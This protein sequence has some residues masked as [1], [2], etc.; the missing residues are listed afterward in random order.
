MYKCIYTGTCC[1]LVNVQ[2]IYIYS[3]EFCTCTC[4]NSLFLVPCPAVCS[5]VR[6]ISSP[7]FFCHACRYTIDTFVFGTVH[8]CSITSYSSSSN[9]AWSVVF[10]CVTTLGFRRI[11]VHV[12][13]HTFFH[14]PCRYMYMYTVDIGTLPYHG[15]L[16]FK[17]KFCSSPLFFFVFAELRPMD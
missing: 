1:F 10:C 3:N 13:I 16:Q 2:Y 14:N 4:M 8:C 17:F 9:F 12:I 11:H 15:K 7:Y 6:Q 5:S